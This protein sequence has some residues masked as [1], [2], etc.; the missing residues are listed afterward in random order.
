MNK[1]KDSYEISLDYIHE[2]YQWKNALKPSN[3]KY[4]VYMNLNT[5]LE[6]TKTKLEYVLGKMRVKKVCQYRWLEK[7][8]PF[9]DFTET[10]EKELKKLREN[11]KIRIYAKLLELM[12]SVSSPSQSSF[13]YNPLIPGL[14]PFEEFID[15]IPKIR[16]DPLKLIF[17]VW[18]KASIVNEYGNIK[19]VKT[20]LEEFKKKTI[21]TEKEYLFDSF[22]EATNLS[23]LRTKALYPKGQKRKNDLYSKLVNF[24]FE[25]SFMR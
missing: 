8:E 10:E 3:V 15:Q 13:D 9:D 17:L 11:F 6:N 4:D 12:E 20:K 18:H 7:K 22:S 14:C 1:A 25:N 23:S 2:L 16:L 5:I 24:I 21:G 19:S